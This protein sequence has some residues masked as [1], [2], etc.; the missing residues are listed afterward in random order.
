M[1]H[2]PLLRAPV[3]WPL[4]TATSLPLRAWGGAEL[5]STI[6]VRTLPTPLQCLLTS[7]FD[8]HVFP[9]SE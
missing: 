5:K 8:C 4:P 7:L 6:L 3:E 1:G 2:L 9:D